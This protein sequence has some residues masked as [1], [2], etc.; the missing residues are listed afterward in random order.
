MT[1]GYALENLN[2]LSYKELKRIHLIFLEKIRAE[3]DNNVKNKYIDICKKIMA[4]IRTREQYSQDEQF[5][6]KNNLV[7]ESAE[8]KEV[9]IR[10]TYDHDIDYSKTGFELNDLY[11]MGGIYKIVSPTG[12][13]FIG[14]SADRIMPQVLDTI[15]ALNLK[16][17]R[18]CNKELLK[19]W[20]L[21]DGE[22][23]F[24][25]SIINVFNNNPNH[26]LLKRELVK[27]LKDDNM[28]TYNS[29]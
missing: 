3:F 14:S 15:N 27:K 12:K 16:K 17:E 21:Y 9:K 20:E 28:E 23:A 10:D 4:E 7:K 5:A 1:I 8:R 19:D 22:K 25:I 29:R 24:K 11:K 18:K 26:I 13:I 6:E 2:S